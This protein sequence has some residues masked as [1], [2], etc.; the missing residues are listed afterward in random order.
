MY[1]LFYFMEGNK[2]ILSMVDDL[3][4][5]VEFAP[6]KDQMAETVAYT[7]YEHILCRYTIPKQ[8]VTD[9]GSNFMSS[10]FVQLCKL[11]GVKK[12]RTTAYHPQSNLVERQHST[13][14]NYLRA[15]TDG[16]VTTW[17]EYLRTAGHAYNNT[18]HVSTGFAPM[19]MLFGF[20]AEIP[21]NLRKS[22]DPVYD[23]GSYIKQLRHKLQYSF[24]MARQKLG[25]KKK[26]AKRYYDK[27][28]HVPD[29]QVN[30]YVLVR[31]KQRTNKLVKPWLGPFIVTEKH[32]NGN[33]TIKSGKGYKRLHMNLLK[34]FSTA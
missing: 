16:K 9:N 11:L 21:T 20:T 7:L 10:V 26:K 33:V 1:L 24:G 15:F 25:E 2:Y 3:T 4:K 22:P 27:K 17:D 32:T 12:L 23:H 31:N 13:L 30:D 6:M 29:I 28:V 14:G 19:E 34:K 8:I 5:F 18:P